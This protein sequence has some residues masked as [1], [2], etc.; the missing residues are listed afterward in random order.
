MAKGKQ[1]T[2][3]LISGTVVGDTVDTLVG[4]DKRDYLRGYGGNDVL[5]GGA[6]SNDVFIFESSLPANGVDNITDFNVYTPTVV[7]GITVSSLADELDLSRVFGKTIKINSNNVDRYVRVH[8][9]ELLVNPDGQ[10]EDWEVWAKFDNN[11]NSAGGGYIGEGD[12]INVRTQTFD[13]KIVASNDG[14]GDI[15]VSTTPLIDTIP[16]AGNFYRGSISGIELT[17]NAA[18]VIKLGKVVIGTPAI[19]GKVTL[20]GSS[21]VQAIAAQGVFSVTNENGVLGTDT[22]GITYALG[23]L[24]ND[25]LTG[26]Y[27]WGY[28]GS[29]T[30]TG[31]D[32]FDWLIGGD[33]GSFIRGGGGA[34]YMFGGSGNDIFIVSSSNSDT[35]INP[36][37]PAESPTSDS[38]FN[39]ATGY[40][41]L[42]LDVA[43]TA[44][45][46]KYALGFNPGTID[47][48]VEALAAARAALDE[49]RL[50]VYMYNIT[51]SGN[52]W[53]YYFS[54]GDP[55]NYTI[56]ELVGLSTDSQF[57]YSDIV[58][59]LIASSFTF[60]STSVGA[61][62]TKAGTLALYDGA[63][64][65]GTS[66]SF[67][68]GALTQTVSVGEQSSLLRTIL[69]VSDSSG[70]FASDTRNV[71][72]GTSAGETIAGVSD[73]VD[74]AI[75]GF[76]GNDT[77]TGGDGV[78]YI[79]GGDG[80]D[81]IRGNKGGDILKG[82][83]GTDTFV[84]G[85]FNDGTNFSDTIGGSTLP[86]TIEDFAAGSGGD[87][88]CFDDNGFLDLNSSSL[89]YYE[90]LSTGNVAGANV[91]VITDALD[92]LT[93]SAAVNTFLDGLTGRTGGY[94]GV[95]AIFKTSAGGDAQVWFDY[96]VG[97]GGTGSDGGTEHLATLTGVTDLSLL[98]VTNFLVV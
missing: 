80:S 28:G 35:G 69:K 73:A 41:R 61:T 2:T 64:L 37:G 91:I 50:Y 72:L 53:L 6:T 65:V 51:N 11:G 47:N 5:T 39:F 29:D 48:D 52:S 43:G 40:D 9:N 10:G 1:N 71:A 23:T 57:V 88:L 96:V 67:T 60:T 31:T 93:T 42:S 86:D 82:E 44:A 84:Y 78:D 45:N 95:I 38:V 97:F 33:G 76:G 83:A 12:L 18:G 30:I 19:D 90:G 68:S 14:G 70:N 36:G 21:G 7:G 26:Q 13:G 75:Y 54:G 77:L 87:V 22:S 58:S 55:S 79:F 34:D 4:T 94:G 74:E 89:S 63:T 32:G 62:S 98:D 85:V 8:N 15:T 16:T 20:G 66:A 46:F 81:V 25:T 27:V 59:L 17:S 56:V 49:G 3:A 92:T 24:G